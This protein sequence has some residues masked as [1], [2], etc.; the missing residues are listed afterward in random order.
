MHKDCVF[1]NASFAGQAC[2]VRITSIKKYDS[3][4][5]RFWKEFF[6]QYGESATTKE[7][8]DFVPDSEKQL[9][10]AIEEEMD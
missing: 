3:W 7:E 5:L 2:M 1:K 9:D 6:N 8:I 4:D 10:E